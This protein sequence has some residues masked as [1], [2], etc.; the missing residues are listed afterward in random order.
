VQPA[1]AKLRQ[2]EIERTARKPTESL[3]AY[4]LYLRALA[5]SHKF[6]EKSLHEAIALVNRALVIDPS[7]APAAAMIGWCRTF[8]KLQGWGP[9]SDAEVAEA[10]HLARQAIEAGRDDPDALWMA[11]NTVSFFASDHATA[12]GAIDRALTLNPSSAHAWFASGMLSYRQYRPERAVEAFKRGMRLS[13]LDP[14]GYLF[15]AGLAAVHVMAGRYE[16]AIEWADRSLRELPRY[17]SA[18]R[19]RLIACAHLD[20]IE[21][22]RDGLVRLLEI[23][24]GLTIARYKALYTV[25]HP[26][27]LIGLQLE[28]LRKA[29]LPEE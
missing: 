24:P 7:Y 19:N 15:T 13:P 20:R 29:G 25:T 4:D 3:D 6:T 5:E 11:A 17:E 16:E 28:G 14:L 10:V 9:L 8:Q 2:S 1:S 23:T 12:A 18:I 26:P 21:E 27:E 22:A